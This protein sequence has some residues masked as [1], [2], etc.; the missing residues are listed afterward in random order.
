MIFK[1]RLVLVAVLVLGVMN[2]VDAKRKNCKNDDSKE[3]GEK[4]KCGTA[5]V[6]C[7]VYPLLYVPV[8]FYYVPVM[9][10]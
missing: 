1:L 10:G 2:G 7:C 5:C 3:V 4:G 8:P 6:M 9:I